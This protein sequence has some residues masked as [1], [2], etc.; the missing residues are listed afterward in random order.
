MHTHDRRP[1]LLHAA[2]FVLLGGLA[3][4]AASAQPLSM[5]APEYQAAKERIG[6]NYESARENCDR[7]AGNAK[8]ICDAEA[9]GKQQVQEAEL[10]Y[11]RSGADEDAAKVDQVRA[12]AAYEVAK[13][14]CDD[15]AGNEKDVCLREA[16]ATQ[17]RAK[18]DGEATA[19]S[20]S[21]RREA[22]GEKRDADYELA[23]ER[24]NAY[25]GDA[26]A[27]CVNAAKARYQKK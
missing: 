4:G 7:L 15:R 23:L 24:C 27:E 12:D 16:R 1:G 20:T 25:S 21:A 17:V 14:M 9:K 3:A 26:K 5:S 8:D 18:A 11:R 19:T 2:A 22:A 10:D 13:E 6:D